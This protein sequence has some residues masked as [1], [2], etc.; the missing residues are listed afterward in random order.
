MLNVF[1]KHLS[2]MFVCFVGSGRTSSV[3]LCSGPERHLF[4]FD[5][6][7]CLLCNSTALNESLLQLAVWV[8]I[9][10]VKVVTL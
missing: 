4:A 7:W 1:S 9:T 3:D 10:A 8:S 2:V 6:A 5:L